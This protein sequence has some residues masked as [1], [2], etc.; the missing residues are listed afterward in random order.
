M[1]EELQEQLND[2]YEAT[3]LKLDCLMI[4]L[5]NKF[6]LIEGQETILEAYYIKKYSKEKICMILQCIE[7][8]SIYNNLLTFLRN[9]K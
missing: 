1:S 7:I 4:D 5:E 6:I 3:E 9:L 2:I 8:E